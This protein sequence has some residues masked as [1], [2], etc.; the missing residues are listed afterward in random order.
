MASVFY[1][2]IETSFISILNAFTIIFDRFDVT[3]AQ[4]SEFGYINT[5]TD[6]IVIA[7]DI[8]QSE[9][10]AVWF[11]RCYLFYYAKNS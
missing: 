9:N 2:L 5:N 11:F 4:H 1:I 7:N 8:C 10:A 6:G 3:L